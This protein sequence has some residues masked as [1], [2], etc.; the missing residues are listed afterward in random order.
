MQIGQVVLL[1][2]NG[3]VQKGKVEKINSNNLYIRLENDELVWRKFWE[4]NKIKNE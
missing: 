3:T 1:K 2:H 4:I